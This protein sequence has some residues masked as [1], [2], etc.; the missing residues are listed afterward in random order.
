VGQAQQD[1][2]SNRGSDRG[3]R[4]RTL[5][6]DAMLSAAQPLSDQPLVPHLKES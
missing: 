5:L 3:I 6:N 4:A 1:D 2:R